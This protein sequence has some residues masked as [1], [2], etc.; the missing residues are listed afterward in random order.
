MD[1]RAELMRLDRQRPFKPFSVRL[2]DGRSFS[3]NRPRLFA[4]G[5]TTVL[6]GSETRLLAQVPLNDVVSIE[7]LEPAT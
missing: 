1:A 2:T 4:L 5:L 7:E 3:I 6:I